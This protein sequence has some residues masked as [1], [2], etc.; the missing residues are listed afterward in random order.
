MIFFYGRMRRSD[1]SS[2]NAPFFMVCD[3]K[4]YSGDSIGL[5]GTA[6][7]IAVFGTT[8]QWYQTYATSYSEY[9]EYNQYGQLNAAGYRYYYAAIG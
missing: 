8:V 4:S 7:Y 9:P 5:T 1:N 3:A 6:G 2:R